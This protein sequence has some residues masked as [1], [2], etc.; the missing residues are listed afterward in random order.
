MVWNQD[1]EVEI[2]GLDEFKVLLLLE[3]TEVGL[4]WFGG[5]EPKSMFFDWST[6]EDGVN[7]HMAGK[8]RG[9]TWTNINKFSPY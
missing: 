5:D 1:G 8:D 6:W 9:G 7:I 4:D 3:L 2:E